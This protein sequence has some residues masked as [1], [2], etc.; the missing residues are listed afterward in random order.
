MGRSPSPSTSD[1]KMVEI[2]NLFFVSFSLCTC[3][4]I[5]L[6]VYEYEYLVKFSMFVCTGCIKGRGCR[7]LA[8]LLFYTE[9]DARICKH[10]RCSLRMYLGFEQRQTNFAY[11]LG[12]TTRFAFLDLCIF[13]GFR[14]EVRDRIKRRHQTDPSYPLDR[15][16]FTRFGLKS[17]K[18]NK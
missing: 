12:H 2:R 17:K 14:Q 13:E 5:H 4:V 9:R 6:V 3:N 8:L 15:R 7:N 18:E 16:A 11:T 10:R 1:V